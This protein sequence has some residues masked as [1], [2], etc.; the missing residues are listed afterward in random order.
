MKAI[1]LAATM[2]VAACSSVLGHEVNNAASPEGSSDM[3]W[4]L[5][6]LETFKIY[7]WIDGQSA[8]ICTYTNPEIANTYTS[9]IARPAWACIDAK[10]RI[11]R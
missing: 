6:P 5:V 11:V 1:F 3:K 10:I 8:T 2:A 4:E 7:G 9:L